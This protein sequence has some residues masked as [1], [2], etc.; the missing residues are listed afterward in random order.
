MVSPI[1]FWRRRFEAIVGV[2]GELEVSIISS[3]VRTLKWDY[4]FNDGVESQLEDNTRWNAR[5]NV[6]FN[7]TVGLVI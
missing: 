1:G 2:G 7:C 3:I 5:M 4:L 6:C